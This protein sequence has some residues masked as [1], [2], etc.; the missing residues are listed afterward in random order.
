MENFSS[1]PLALD[2]P[3]RVAGDESLFAWSP[4]EE[5]MEVTWDSSRSNS[6]FYLPLG[7][8]LSRADDFSVSFELVLEDIM[9]GLNPEKPFSFEIALGF[10]HLESALQ[11]S[12]QRGTAAGVKNIVEFNYFPPFSFYAPTVALTMVSS[13]RQFAYSHNFPLPLN[14]RD[15]YQVELTHTAITTALGAVLLRNGEPVPLAPAYPDAAFTD[16]RVDAFAISSYSDQGADGSIL[17]HGRVDNVRLTYP[18]PPV[19]R[20]AGGWK[21]GHWRVTFESRIHWTYYLER[22]GSMEAWETLPGAVAGDG[23][24]LELVDQEPPVRGFYR[25]RAERP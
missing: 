15:V 7:A 6:F 21:E 11:S 10:I 8:T 19:E 16:F 13:N 4:G 5:D 22:T 14:V 17:A 25:V 3:W 23:S 1:D 24:T 2:S 18:P 9:S 20:I 12:F